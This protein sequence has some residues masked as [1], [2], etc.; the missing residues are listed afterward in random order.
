MIDVDGFVTAGGRSSRMGEDKAW[1]EINGRP[2]I[3]RV[4]SAV[5]EATPR[6]SLI[7]NDASYSSF[8]LPVIPDVNR[9]IGPLEAIRVALSRTSGSYALM[10]GCD[11]PMVTS[12]LLLFLLDLREEYEAVVPIGPDGKWET[13]CAVYSRALLP[14]A[15]TLI[16]QGARAVRSL[17]DV[18][19]VRT[20][21][22]EELRHLG[23]SKSFFENVNSQADYERVVG[24]LKAI[25]G[26]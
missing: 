4:I 13:M 1:L 6:V 16:E 17:L 15:T 25:S 5:R 9:G 23:G 22:F 19:N 14:K 8:G 26:R 18:A 24:L 21:P 11:L 3:E 10:V 12:E 20:V 7:A 2:M